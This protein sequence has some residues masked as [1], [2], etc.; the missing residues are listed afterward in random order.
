[1]TKKILFAGDLFVSESDP[2]RI[3]SLLDGYLTDQLF[4]ANLE[5]APDFFGSRSKKAVALSLNQSVVE[6]LSGSGIYYSIVNNHTG[7]G[8]IDVYKRLQRLLANGGLASSV[9][10]KEPRQFVD[11]QPLIFFADEREECPCDAMGFLRFDQSV[12]DEYS[13]YID[14]SIV[15]VHGG[16]EY[17][18]EPTFYQRKL[19]HHMI[20]LGATSVIFHHSHIK[21]SY[22]WY[23]DRLI[24]YGLGNFYFSHVGDMHGL[25]TINGCVLQYD[26]DSGSFSEAEV[27]YSALEVDASPT[28]SLEFSSLSPSTMLVPLSSYRNWYRKRYRMDSSFRPRQLSSHEW[29]IR[30]QWNAWYSV[31]SVMV[32]MGITARVKAVLKWMLRR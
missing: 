22:E 8:G 4:V 28:L 5:G 12:I 10:Q 30:W 29:V 15:I 2:I 16:I 24:H 3:S 32:R 20:D 21:G 7:D 27:V 6:D 25:E 18:P 9:H 26:R 11:G 13:N 1:M 14:G 17:R 19:S 31:A 23:G